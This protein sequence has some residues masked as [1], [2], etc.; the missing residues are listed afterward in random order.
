MF[1][2]KELSEN[3]QLR[4]F[5]VMLFLKTA[6]GSKNPEKETEAELRDLLKTKREWRRLRKDLFHGVNR[7]RRKMGLRALGS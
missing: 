1:R 6:D 4:V 2:L 3:Q 7:I 5:Q